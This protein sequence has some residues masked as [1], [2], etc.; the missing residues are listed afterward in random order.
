MSQ[1]VEYIPN[2][3]WILEY[4]VHYSGM[5]L[6]ARMTLIRLPNGDLLVH[7]P[8]RIDAAV[9]AQIDAIGPVRYIVAPG[10]Y[11]HLYVT[12]FQREYPA[13]ETWLCPGL[14]RKRP[15]IPFDWILGNR[16]DHRWADVLDQVL[17]QGTKYLWEVAFF[18]KPSK[19]L[20]LVDLLE[21][22][23]NDYRH[24][25]GPGLRFWWKWIFRM[26]GRPKAAPEYQMGWGDRR[27]V[28]RALETIIGWDANRIILAHGELVERDVGKTL[29]TAWRK[30]LDA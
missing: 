8:C 12:D 5:D 30:V 6:F 27:V 26:W 18:H 14:E 2:Q 17:V 29:T 9:K 7:D 10:S 24:T 20:I 22:I 4:P 19:T 28:R 16:P 13:A 21:N 3:L 23:G 15:D 25:A 1:L 11:H